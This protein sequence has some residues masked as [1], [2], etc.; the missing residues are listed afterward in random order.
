MSNVSNEYF[1]GVAT[2]ASELDDDDLRHIADDVDACE[3]CT[4]DRP[5]TPGLFDSLDDL[6]TDDIIAHCHE[7]DGGIVIPE[8]NA[9]SAIAGLERMYLTQ[10]ELLESDLDL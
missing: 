10:H 5:G 8:P 4:F 1:F 9:L 6:S 7:L 2:H 3:C